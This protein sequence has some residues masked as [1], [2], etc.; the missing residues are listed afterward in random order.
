M[1]LDSSENLKQLWEGW[2]HLV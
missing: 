2:R 1:V